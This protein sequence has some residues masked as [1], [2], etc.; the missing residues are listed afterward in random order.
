MMQPLM[1]VIHQITLKV[2]ALFY[3]VDFRSSPDEHFLY[4]TV[5]GKQTAGWIDEHFRYHTVS[6]KQTA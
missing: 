6:G 5:S 2:E 4:H 3:T 1:L